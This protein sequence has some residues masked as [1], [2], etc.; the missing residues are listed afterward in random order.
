MEGGGGGGGEGEVGGHCGLFALGGRVRGVRTKGL[1]WDIDGDVGWDTVMSTN[2]LIDA[3]A[4][5]I[6]AEGG[7]DGQLVW[8]TECGGG[9]AREGEGVG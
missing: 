3:D 9:Q 6:E 8:T 5:D 2:N 4:V 1:R 7:G